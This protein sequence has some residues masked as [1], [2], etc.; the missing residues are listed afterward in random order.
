MKILFLAPYPEYESPSQRYRFEHY[1]D[2]L[3]DDGF[4][5]S[6]VP[7]LSMSGWKIFFSKGN[8]LKKI[9]SVC[10]G[11]ARRWL[12][13]FNLRKYDFV[14]IHRE[15]AP[16]GPPIF[17]WIIAK[18]C[19]KKIIYD[20]DDAIWVPIASE[21]NKLAR[22]IK[23]F[24][25]IATICRLSYKASAGNEYLAN[26]AR[27][28]CK[29]VIVIPTVVNTEKT[30][31]KI[32]NH[33]VDELVIG[34]TGTFSTLKYLDIIVPVLKRLQAK[35]DFLFLVIANKDPHLPLPRYRFIEWEKDT[36]VDDLLKMHIGVM[37]LYDSD[38]EKGKCGFKAIQYMSL[39]IPPVVSPVGVNKDIVL[40]GENGFIADSAE[41]W[42][43]YLEKL[44][45]NTSL[46][47]EIGLKARRTIEAKFSV[48]STWQQFK[49]LFI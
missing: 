26:F 42:E 45:T 35:Y 49:K 23:W 20:F 6:Y 30:H 32:Q 13:I 46:R 28:F 17:E 10:G 37:P 12:L 48:K 39:G 38:I 2:L 34:W 14:Y 11:F 31:N 1:F 18:I 16:I 25:K 7:F 41:E 4:S 29:N 24:S 3:K 19:K 44:I 15:A 9:F 22:Y 5:Y 21:N 33:L 47:N 8:S 36:E 43:I 40:H 27:Q